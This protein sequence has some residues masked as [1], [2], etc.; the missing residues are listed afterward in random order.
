MKSEWG[1]NELARHLKMPPSSLHR[2]L[3]SLKEENI[4]ELVESSQKYRIG[5]DLIR[6]SS[7]ISTHVD[8]KSIAR[9]FLEGL[10]AKLK[11]PVYFSLYYPQHRK[12]AFI[13]SIKSSFA[14]Q[15]VLD[16]GV[17]QPIHVASSGKSILAFLTQQE[18]DAVLDQEGVPVSERLKVIKELEYIK[19][20]GYAITSN[21]RK[22][23]ALSVGAPIFK[24][25]NVIIG[26]IICVMPINEFKEEEKEFFIRSVKET[27][28]SISYVLGSSKASKEEE[29]L[30][31]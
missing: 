24:A 20:D 17:L 8:V 26:S 16:I 19:N 27:A 3:T 4:V 18:I 12:L 25:N 10:K 21:E 29:E 1:V 30:M 14:L 2:M 15:Y 31:I 22:E 6:M 7:L 9:P 23:G 11:H 5:M 28:E 13:D